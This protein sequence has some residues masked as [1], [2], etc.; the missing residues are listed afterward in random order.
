MKN[1]LFLFFFACGMAIPIDANSQNRHDNTWI[2]GYGPYLPDKFFGG[3][4]ID[5]S[6]GTPTIKHFGLPNFDLNSPCSIS[7][8]SGRL[9]FYT[10]GC[11]IHNREHA[12]MEN[13]DDLN[14]G[15]I[16]DQYCPF[17]GYPA[18]QSLLALPFP[19]HEGR[20]VLFHMRKYSLLT[21]QYDLLFSEVDMSANNGLGRVSQKNVL[22]LTDTLTRSATAVRHGNGR[23]WWI[24]VPRELQSTYHLFL[25]DTA[26]IHGPM[27]R[28]PESAWIHGHNYNV[29]GVFSPDGAKYVRGG[30][31]TPPM[32]RLYDFDRCAG[33]LSNARDIVLPDT[34]AYATYFCFSPNSRYLYV[35]NEG[36]HLYQYD[37]WAADISASIK[38]VG[39]YDGFLSVYNLPTAFSA[40]ALGPD[41]KIY[42]SCGNGTN[43]LHTIHRPDEPGVAC[44]FRQ[45]DLILPA[46]TKFY[47]P[48]M[49]NFRLYA[50][51]GSSCDS[52]GVEPPIVAWWRSEVDSTAGPGTVFDFFDLSYHQPVTWFWD[53]GDGS[54]D[55]SANPR[56]NFA[57]PGLYQVCLTVCNDAGLC[58]TLCREI[59]I[60]TSAS[61]AVLSGQQGQAVVLFPN[62]ADGHV[63]VKNLVAGQKIRLDLAN[64]LCQ[65]VL[66]VGLAEHDEPQKIGLSRL[67]SGFYTWRV[68]D[69]VG[70]LLGTGKL[71]LRH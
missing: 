61:P 59:N 15:D 22:I 6:D 60:E 44:D 3:N 68:T 24:V 47:L 32:F 30:S 37:T 10:N 53:F 28:Q 17:T 26:G 50:M 51:P 8:G 14:D 13:G 31:R 66:S 4:E 1:L 62:P 20:Y 55:S 36:W 69:A 11:R 35:N 33:E 42:M 16:F 65:N 9:Q 41:G 57:A 48:N 23:D 45:H 70:K 64:A 34:T 52:L 71:I 25:L 5:F 19:G 38:E 29:A 27:T 21:A 40:T 39:L 7:D 12:I 56:H 18:Y 63:W 58:D 67:P 46:H 54:T 49:P 43:V 2:L